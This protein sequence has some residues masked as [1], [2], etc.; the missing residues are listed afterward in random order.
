MR[1]VTWLYAG[2]FSIIV[3]ACELDADREIIAARPAEELGRA[4]M[5]RALV[6]RHELHEFAVAAYQEVRGHAH[7]AQV[8]LV[9]GVRIAV[10]TI[11]EQRLDRVTAEFAGRQ[12]DV[13]DDHERR[14]RTCGP[15]LEVRRRRMARFAHPAVRVNRQQP[16][17]AHRAS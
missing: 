6:A 1:D 5:P 9:I 8:A 14:H 16:R 10:E 15:H 11:Q 12:A 7:V 4:R 2:S 3:R 13:V 17:V